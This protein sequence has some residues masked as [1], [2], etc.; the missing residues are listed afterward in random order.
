M[1]RMTKQKRIMIESLNK[2]DNFF[3]AVDLHNQVSKKMNVGIATIY[4]FLS[5][6]EK[7]SKIH[8]YMCKGRKIYSKGRTNHVHFICESCNSSKH[9]ELD[10][11]DFISDFKTKIC[12]FQ[13][14]MFGTCD[15]CASNDSP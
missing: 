8:W 14:D 1:K 15:K 13:L 3:D 9:V 6:L 2:F 4:R 7:E 11:I 12:H 10:K 5:D